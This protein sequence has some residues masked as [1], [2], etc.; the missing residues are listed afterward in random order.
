M[1]GFEFVIVGGIVIALLWLGP[2]KLPE[3]ARSI[4]RTVGEFRRGRQEFHHDVEE[5]GKIE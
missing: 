5:L 1:E 4:G 3:L 2:K